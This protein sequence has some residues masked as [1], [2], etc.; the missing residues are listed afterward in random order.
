MRN[1]WQISRE[2]SDKPFDGKPRVVVAQRGRRI[3]YRGFGD[4]ERYVQRSCPCSVERFEEEACLHGVTGA[5]LEEFFGL[6]GVHHLVGVQRE[7][8]G[9]CSCEVVLGELC[10]VFEELRSSGIVE[11][12]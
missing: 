12:L 5:K 6:D 7:D 2:V 1:P 9:F 11:V 8:L 3:T 10:D 4:V